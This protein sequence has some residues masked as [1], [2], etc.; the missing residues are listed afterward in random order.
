VDGG[1]ALVRA[2]VAADG[3]GFPGSAGPCHGAV[4]VAVWARRSR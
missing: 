1:D 4:I 3:H 2:A